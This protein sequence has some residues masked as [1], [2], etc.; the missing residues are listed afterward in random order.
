MLYQLQ[1][2]SLLHDPIF[3]LQSDHSWR[4][5]EY[6]ETT[7]AGDY[8]T[9]NP[10]DIIALQHSD[11]E[12][13]INEKT[14][15][16]EPSESNAYE[17]FKALWYRAYLIRSGAVPI[18]DFEQ[19]LET[20]ANGDD[21]RG[22]RLVL[23]VSGLFELRSF[24]EDER[25]YKDPSVVVLHESFQARG[26][27]VG[28]KAAMDVNYYM[29]WYT[30]S[31]E[32][33][34][35]HLKTGKCNAYCDTHTDAKLE[36]IEKALG[37]PSRIVTPDSTFPL[38]EAISQS[39]RPDVPEVVDPLPSP[40]VK[41]ARRRKRSRSRRV[42]AWKLTDRL[43][44][45]GNGEVWR[46]E[47]EKGDVRAI[48]LLK[49]IKPKRYARFRDEVNV[50]ESNADV[51]GILSILDKS[52][53]DIS[54]G[55]IP[56][57]VMPIARTMEESSSGKSLEE[58]VDIILEICN[59]VSVL[60]A[61]NITHRDI[62]PSNI[63]CLDDHYYLADFG[64]ADFPEKERLSDP[65]EEIGA[66]WT[67]APEMKRE[68]NTAD[69]KKGD[70]YSLAKTFWILLTGH[71]KGFD[72][73]YTV[74]STIE[75]KRF[76]PDS[77]TEPIDGLLARC[78]DIDPHKR[79]SV[80]ELIQGLVDWKS[81]VKDFHSKNR[82]QWFTLQSKLFPGA[83]PQRA[84]WEKLEDIL[85]VLQAV[86]GEDD[87]N[88][89]L[90]PTGG[91]LDLDGAKLSNEPGCL[92]LNLGRP[93]IVK[94]KRLVFESFSS[95]PEWNYFYLELDFLERA[96]II[97]DDGAMLFKDTDEELSELSPLAYYPFDVLNHREEFEDK[98][99]IPRE[100]R[101]IRRWLKGNMVIVCKRSPYN[102]NPG[103]YDGRH[104]K[105]TVEEFRGY[106]ARSV[107]HSDKKR[108]LT[109]L[110]TEEAAADTHANP[111][112]RDHRI[113]AIPVFRCGYCGD[114]VSEDGKELEAETREYHI[115]IYGIYGG[116][117]TSC[118]TCLDR[119]RAEG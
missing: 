117:L 67:I 110:A 89:M 45:G 52:L 114:I 113:Q 100:A 109:H 15:R 22:N 70:I 61:R 73:Q 93:N 103:T 3:R 28:K 99:F 17:G 72:G 62:K 75:L 2:S 29:P 11:R 87:L 47:N 34:L 43:G 115:R 5:V 7:Q 54:G 60:H 37:I 50:M 66:K 79:P 14:W 20:I 92:E 68:S 90:L 102:L 42:G 25:T 40:T 6:L 59:C 101:L 4:R 83:L 8:T 91:G 108:K 9:A 80:E 81:L 33:W 49:A 51:P 76:Y 24:D 65:N 55:G 118:V 82:R 98:Y 56:Y 119:V 48:K 27:F 58:K 112:P 57:Y 18:P 107:E 84:S 95:T 94:P 77:F 106:I 74:D 35:H 39:A 64:L 44:S 71:K 97:D 30:D 32:A 1:L 23:N 105:M 19:L 53:P 96:E 31:M 104:N 12:L 36:D 21:K 10:E 116:S 13:R 26:G 69:S 16:I 88:H 85:R 41:N 46:C 86:S 111:Q 63:L 38:V 78:T